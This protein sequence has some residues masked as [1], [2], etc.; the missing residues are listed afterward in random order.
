MA[1][2]TWT[3]SKTPVT[4][5]NPPNIDNS[6]SN[7]AELPSPMFQSLLTCITSNNAVD[8]TVVESIAENNNLHSVPTMNDKADHW[9]DNNGHPLILWFP[10]ILDTEGSFGRMGLY[11]N[12]PTRSSASKKNG[13]WM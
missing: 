13:N 9:V 10:A 12:L 4:P 7:I 11:F 3:L 1:S 6:M 5:H 8:Q 2:P